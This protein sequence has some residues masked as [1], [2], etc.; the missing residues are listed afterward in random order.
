[1]GFHGFDASQERGMRNNL[2][3]Y[4]SFSQ[5]YRDFILVDDYKVL[6]LMHTYYHELKGVGTYIDNGELQCN[7][8]RVPM[9]L[10]TGMCPKLFFKSFS[11]FS[12]IPE[13]LGYFFPGYSFSV[14]KNTGAVNF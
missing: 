2:I 9:L 5:L 6:I 11:T 8:F 10:N 13:P 4:S 14:H 7:K 1:M 12:G 3:I